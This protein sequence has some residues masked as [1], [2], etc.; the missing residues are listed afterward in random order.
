MKTLFGRQSERREEQAPITRSM[1]KQKCQSKVPTVLQYLQPGLRT[2]M[3]KKRINDFE[4]LF[5]SL[6]FKAIAP[7]F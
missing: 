6:C 7:P 5:Q 3:G 2:D 4:G 1:L